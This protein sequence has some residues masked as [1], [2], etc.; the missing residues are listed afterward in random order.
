MN[1]RSPEGETVPS[2]DLLPGTLDLLVLKTLSL[3]PLH[4]WG[5]AQRIEQ[6]SR[7]TFRVNQGS[8]YPAL[9]RLKR[10]GLI[11]SEWEVTEHNRRAR[12]YRLTADGRARLAAEQREWERSAA[13]MGWVLTATLSQVR[14]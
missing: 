2:N 13:A 14:P 1:C 5:I 10:Q 4:G 11:R 6:L 7:D 3:E 12:F 8:L 9:Q